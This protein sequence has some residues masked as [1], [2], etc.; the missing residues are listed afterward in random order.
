MRKATI[1]LEG[2]HYL[3]HLN[4]RSYSKLESILELKSY[5]DIYTNMQ[6]G[7]LSI[8]DSLNI[9]LVALEKEYPELTMDKLEQLLENEGYNSKQIMEKVIL[10]IGEEMQ[11]GV[12]EGKEKVIEK[13]N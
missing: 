7:K 10:A 1:K 9:L 5:L 11:S 3:L 2:K 6:N 4:F 13:K 8:S 12:K